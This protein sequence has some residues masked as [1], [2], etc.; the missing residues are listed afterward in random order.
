MLYGHKEEKMKETSYAT[1]SKQLVVKILQD[2]KLMDCIVNKNCILLRHLELC[3]TN[4]CPLNC[5]YCVCKDMNKEE[6][7][8]PAQVKHILN[9]AKSLGCRAITLTG[10]GEPLAHPDINE[11]IDYCETTNINVGLVTNGVLLDKLNSDVTWCRISFDSYRKLKKI[12]NTINKAVKKFPKTDWAFS[13]VITEKLGDLKAVVQLANK[14]NFTHARITNDVLN[15]DNEL[16][17]KARKELRGIDKK[18]IYQPR[19]RTTRGAKRC[20]VSL[21][22]PMIAADGKIYPCCA[23]QCAINGEGGSFPKQTIM[24]DYI[25]L[26]EIITKQKYFNGSIC[27]VCYYN[28]YNELLETLMADINHKEWV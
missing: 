11:I 1:A 28:H 26:E 22:R 14:L 9:T 21:L 5:K 2:T 24:G 4:K 13:I 3:I 15:P 16:M 19:E 20:L 27:D 17:E 12:K 6:E 23:V 18:V 7:L 10:G 8:L 25:E